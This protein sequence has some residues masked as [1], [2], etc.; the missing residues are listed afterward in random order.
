MAEAYLRQGPLAHLHLPARRG[1]DG[2]E[3]GVNAKDLGFVGQWNLRGDAGDGGFGA[4]L[5]AE[6]GAAL[7]SDPNTASEGRGGVRLL[8]LGPDEWLVVGP[9]GGG[10]GDQL[11]AALDGFHAA[12]T[13]V[14]ESRAVIELTGSGVRGL[15]AKGCALDFHDRVFAEGRC[16]QSTLA[17]AH[18]IVHRPAAKT[19][20]YQ[21]Y[22]HRSFAEYLWTWIEDAAGEY[23]LIVK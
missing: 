12:V 2:G 10:L 9:D 21:V 20:T 8:W 16:A 18:V 13:D 5:E 4:A 19:P 7:P 11:S 23:G 1:E 14:G 6:F 17:R 3:G 22:V 15:L